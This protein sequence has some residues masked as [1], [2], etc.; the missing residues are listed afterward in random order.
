MSNPA[1][2]GLARDLR[3][4]AAVLDELPADLAP[5]HYV[6]LD[7]Q[8]WPFVGEDETRAVVDA[9]GRAFFAA[10]GRAGEPEP[11]E[12]RPGDEGRMHYSAPNVEIGVVKVR[13]YGGWNT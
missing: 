11:V 13:V 12:P 9:L 2:E 10:A 3:A 4:I 6:A 1:Y 8:P 7:I 5:V